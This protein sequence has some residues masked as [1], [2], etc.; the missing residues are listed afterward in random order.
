MGETERK[1]VRN[2]LILGAGEG[3]FL[4]HL[5][6]PPPTSVF[7]SS[8]E[9]TTLLCSSPFFFSKVH[10]AFTSRRN[11]LWHMAAFGIA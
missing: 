9:V 4:G 3:L 2:H 11:F 6:L 10:T 8:F 7:Q 1:W 5:C